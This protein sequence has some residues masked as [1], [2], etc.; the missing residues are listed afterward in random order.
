MNQSTLDKIRK[1]NLHLLRVIENYNEEKK[2]EIWA[3]LI[4][5]YK[6]NER[7]RN[8]HDYEGHRRARLQKMKERNAEIV[9]CPICDCKLKYSSLTKHKN[10]NKCKLNQLLKKELTN[11]FN[12]SDK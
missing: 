6:E 4:A 7:L 3:G 12:K 8:K 1:E 10:N 9:N 2:Q 5:N 11:E